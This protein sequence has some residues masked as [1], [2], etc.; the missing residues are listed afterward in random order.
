M[1]DSVLANEVV[2]ELQ[3]KRMRGLC[4]KVHYEKAYDSY[5]IF[6]IIC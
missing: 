2:K 5:G 3:K 1:L 4:L 6:S